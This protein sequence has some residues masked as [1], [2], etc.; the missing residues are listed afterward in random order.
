MPLID[1]AEY[2]AAADDALIDA[3]PLFS[4]MDFR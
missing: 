4:S 2:F 3:M 1:Y